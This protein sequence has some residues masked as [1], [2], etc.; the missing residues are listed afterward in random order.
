VG[1][2]APSGWS[3]VPVAPGGQGSRPRRGSAT[4]VG[5][6]AGGPD[7]R[8]VTS[9]GSLPRAGRRAAN[10]RKPRIAVR[11]AAIARYHGAR[12]PVLFPDGWA[13]ALWA[14]ADWDVEVPVSAFAVVAA[15]GCL[16]GVVD[17]AAVLAGD[18][19]GG[20]GT[21]LFVRSRH[22]SS[23]CAGPEPMDPPAMAL[24]RTTRN[25]AT[26]AQSLIARTLFERAAK[27]RYLT[28][29]SSDLRKR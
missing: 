16:T 5:R 29:T 28:L 17:A 27:T 26:R 7:S 13:T 11:P 18:V 23:A 24:A 21:K 8:W 10:R 19:E 3:S 2:G 14:R 12:L 1:A 25:S 4:G 22:K 6:P 15:E 9:S 20:Q